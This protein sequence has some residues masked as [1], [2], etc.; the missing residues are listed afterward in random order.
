MKSLYKYLLILT[1][2]PFILSIKNIYNE[3][4]YGYLYIQNIISLY[5][6]FIETLI[7]KFKLKS[8]K[9]PLPNYFISITYV[10][11]IYTL[12][13]LMDGYIGNDIK[14]ITIIIIL[15]SLYYIS[16]SNFKD[17][18]SIDGLMY[19]SIIFA[20]LINI[21]LTFERDLKLLIIGWLLISLMNIF[22]AIKTKN[23]WPLLISFIAPLSII[24]QAGL[25][26][27]YVL[28]FIIFFTLSSII[29]YIAFLIDK[30]K[31]YIIGPLIGLYLFVI[32]NNIV[33]YNR[34]NLYISLL[35][36]IISMIIYYLLNNLYK[37]R[38]LFIATYASAMTTLLL[39]NLFITNL[40]ITLYIIT[41]LLLLKFRN[42]IKL[43]Y[44][45]LK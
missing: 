43:K 31:I 18:E 24:Y 37:T 36:T 2:I 45:T 16:W 4:L 34:I 23:T 6:I 14:S 39:I 12:N 29:S 27:V 13:V 25:T 5:I 10:M 33:Y 7:I 20:S 9:N 8:L 17:F 22:L 3:N 44:Y 30:N 26:D 19:P 41:I 35:F 15:N 1:I 42:L 21:S 11:L 28:D 38:V 32:V 40:A